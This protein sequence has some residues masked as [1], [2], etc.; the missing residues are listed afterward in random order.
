[1]VGAGTKSDFSDAFVGCMRVG[2]M[3]RIKHTCPEECFQFVSPTMP[4]I[5]GNAV[6]PYSSEL[7]AKDA[8][9]WNASVPLV[10]Y[11]YDSL[12]SGACGTDEYP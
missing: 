6:E 2:S 1:M 9:N 5:I 8:H 12:P 10:L 11:V 3:V 4:Y 7:R